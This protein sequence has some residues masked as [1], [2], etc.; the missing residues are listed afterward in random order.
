MFFAVFMTCDTPPKLL[1]RNYY[2]EIAN[3]LC[4]SRS[5]G[6]CYE[7]ALLPANSGD[8]GAPGRRT[9]HRAHKQPQ[10][11]PLFYRTPQPAAIGPDF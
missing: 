9:A 10:T 8:Y 11:G 3:V 4:T 5:D 2:A 6:F 7:K 1:L